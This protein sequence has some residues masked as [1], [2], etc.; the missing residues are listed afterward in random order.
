MGN[1]SSTAVIE[2]GY[3]LSEDDHLLLLQIRN[4]LRLLATLAAPRSKLDDHHYFEL[5]ACALYEN[6]CDLHDAL[7]SIARNAQWRAGS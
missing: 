7:D 5:P 6:Y 4:Q 3:I 1:D 2:M